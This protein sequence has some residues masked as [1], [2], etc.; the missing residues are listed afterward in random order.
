MLTNWSSQQ[1]KL[2]G[3][4]SQNFSVDKDDITGMSRQRVVEES[5]RTRFSTYLI[6][7]GANC[8]IIR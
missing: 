2:K 1:E 3:F 4:L 6:S 5:W 7:F 8:N